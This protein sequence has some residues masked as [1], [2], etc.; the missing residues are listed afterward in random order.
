MFIALLVKVSRNYLINQHNFVLSKNTLTFVGPLRG[1]RPHETRR[2]SPIEDILVISALGTQKS[3]IHLLLP[4]MLTTLLSFLSDTE[5]R[6]REWV[7]EW[8][9][10]IN[11]SLTH[12]HTHCVAVAVTVSKQ[13]PD[14]FL[15]ILK[16]KGFRVLS[17][18]TDSL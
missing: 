15:K 1:P 12:T 4:S 7:T 3:Y 16:R 8:V 2:S 10:K 11:T 14:F 17:D 13:I 6:K 9:W 5:K 18:F